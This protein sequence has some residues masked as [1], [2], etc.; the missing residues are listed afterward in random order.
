MTDRQALGIDPIEPYS[1]VVKASGLIHV[2]SQIGRDANGGYPEDVEGQTHQTL[3]NLEH[4]LEMAGVSVHNV[5][6]IHVYMADIDRDFDGM[7]KSYGAFFDAR[8]V[9]E[10][11]ARTTVGTPLSWPQLLVQMD[12][13]ALDS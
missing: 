12:L 9:V 6:K 1:K 4:A 8:S 3:E 13:V 2:K 7:N 11:P 10:Q 5:M